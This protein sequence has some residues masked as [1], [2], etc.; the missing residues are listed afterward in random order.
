MNKMKRYSNKQIDVLL[1]DTA[2]I[3]YDDE[4]DAVDL[5]HRNGGD[6]GWSSYG[7][8]FDDDPFPNQCGMGI[9]YQCRKNRPRGLTD[10]VW[11][12]IT[13]EAFLRALDYY[14]T[15]DE[16]T[17]YVMVTSSRE[18]PDLTSVCE[19]L[20]LNKVFRGTNPNSGHRIEG[21]IIPMFPRNAVYG[22]AA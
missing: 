1:K 20:G 12:T 17:G 9:L 22:K 14:Y 4:D 13:M 5:G 19:R 15:E 21:W 16:P 6:D 3:T 2:W 11:D 7:I 8:R 10:A 18:T